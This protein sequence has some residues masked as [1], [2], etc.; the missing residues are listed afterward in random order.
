[1]WVSGRCLCGSVVGDCS[2]ETRGPGW[3]SEV[4]VMIL[5]G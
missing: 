4:V 5:S 3:S 1:M 2:S